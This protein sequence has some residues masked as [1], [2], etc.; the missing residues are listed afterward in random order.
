MVDAIV[1]VAVMAGFIFA[2]RVVGLIWWSW[3][4]TGLT[5]YLALFEIAARVE[6][7]LTISQQFWAYSLNHPVGAWVLA[8]MVGFGGIGLSVHL[9]WKLLFK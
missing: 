5:F 6:T 9:L 2:F 3:F 1:T 4:W 7:R 8:G